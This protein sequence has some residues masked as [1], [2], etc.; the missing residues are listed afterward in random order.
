MHKHHGSAVFAVFTLIILSIVLSCTTRYVK[1]SPTFRK[2][3]VPDSEKIQNDRFHGVPMRCIRTIDKT[4]IPGGGNAEKQEKAM[5]PLLTAIEDCDYELTKKLL[6]S[7][8]KAYEPVPAYYNRT[9]LLSAVLNHDFKITKLLIEYGA[10]VNAQTPLIA[11]STYSD[12]RMA[13]LLVACGADVNKMS[14]D[15]LPL[16]YAIR[17]RAFDTA[18][19]L[20][21]SGADVNDKRCGITP[22]MEA[23]FYQSYN[24]DDPAYL[25]LLKSLID[26]GANPNAEDRDGVS[27]LEHTKERLRKGFTAFEEIEKILEQNQR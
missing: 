3:Q 21:D 4:G 20:I 16:M 27:P 25:D 19:Y 24:Y 12:S 8:A 6:Q 1:E 11:A 26:H 9:P 15:R 13:Q 2:G 7:G 10:D 5:G 18:R 22:L 17:N 23:V 14:N